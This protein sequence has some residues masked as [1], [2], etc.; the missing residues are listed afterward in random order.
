MRWP[1]CRQTDL[2]FVHCCFWHFL[3]QYLVIWQPVHH[4][5]FDPC[6]LYNSNL[7][8]ICGSY[9]PL[10]D[11]TFN[12]AV[13]S[14]L[15]FCNICHFPFAFLLVIV[16]QAVYVSLLWTAV[17]IDGTFCY[18]NGT[19]DTL[20]WQIYIQKF[21]A[22]APHNRT[23]F[24]C[25]YI[26]F[27]QKAPVL[28]VGTLSNKGWHHPNRKSWICPCSV[29][30]TW[31][32]C[33]CC[34]VDRLNLNSFSHVE[35]NAPSCLTRKNITCRSEWSINTFSGILCTFFSIFIPSIAGS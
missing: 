6:S 28:E 21:L 27:H 12:L 2:C 19:H 17:Y 13:M 33:S 20:Q 4:P 10:I 5:Y 35:Q 24:L 15:I 18:N 22:C 25:F 14:M 1:T 30:W 9:L 23:K 11:K 26:C 34:K 8:H 29:Q 16:L 31:P 7:A 3:E 32:R